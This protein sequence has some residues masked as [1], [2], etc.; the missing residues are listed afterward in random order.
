MPIHRLDDSLIH[1]ILL[2]LFAVRGL[3][4]LHTYS[5]SPPTHT[6]S[7]RH[8]SLFLNTAT[9]SSNQKNHGRHGH[10]HYQMPAPNLLTSSKAIVT[11]PVSLLS[12]QNLPKGL[13]A[14][15]A[16]M[17]TIVPA[18]LWV[19][20]NI[21]Q[22]ALNQLN[23]MRSAKAV[24]VGLGLGGGLAAAGFMSTPGV[25]E[26]EIMAV[27]DASSSGDSRGLLLLFVVAPAILW[28]L[29]NILQPALNQLNRMRS[30]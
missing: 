17:T 13:A 19:L 28:V 21:L 3:T 2:T 30:G 23:R 5:L 1:R 20:Y 29:Y 11:K 9:N 12:L 10:P 4:S 16:S 6:S 18:V 8:S 27:A 7:P 24:V 14:A 26:D 25:S 15:A 22:P